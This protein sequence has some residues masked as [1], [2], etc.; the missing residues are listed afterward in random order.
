[1]EWVVR[2]AEEGGIEVLLEDDVVA[3]FPNGREGVAFWMF[4]DGLLRFYSKASVWDGSYG[5]Y[6]AS[7]GEMTDWA[8]EQLSILRERTEDSCFPWPGAE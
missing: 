7:G 2:D 3:R 4:L 5:H 8:K 6:H 1:M